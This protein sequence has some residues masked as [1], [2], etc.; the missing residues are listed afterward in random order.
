MENK[1]ILVTGGCGFIGSN[2]VEKLLTMNVKMV[3]VLDNL[4]TGYKKNINFLLEKYKNTGKLEFLYGDI[5]NLEVCRK[6]M[7]DINLVCHQAALGSVL[8][9][10]MIH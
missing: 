7:K 5:S 1:N 8:D 2:I 3:R 10:S 6:A 9:L 4:S